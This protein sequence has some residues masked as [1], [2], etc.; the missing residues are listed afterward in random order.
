MPDPV[1]ERQTKVQDEFLSTVLDPPPLLGCTVTLALLDRLMTRN[2]VPGC[3]VDGA[4]R[5]TVRLLVNTWVG[6]LD[7]V[8]VVVPEPV[9]LT[10]RGDAYAWTR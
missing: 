4:G 3:T 5:T 7:A 9:V 2:S 10:R 8:R 6:E 1:V